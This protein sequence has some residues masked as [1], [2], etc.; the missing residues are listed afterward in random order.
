MTD[1]STCTSSSSGGG[2]SRPTVFASA[3]HCTRILIGLITNAGQGQG[4]CAAERTSSGTQSTL[5]IAARS[6]AHAGAAATHATAGTAAGASA[7]SK[8]AAPA[9]CIGA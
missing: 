3:S 6:A 7:G 9:A 4:A 1:G 2:A 8:Q 5:K